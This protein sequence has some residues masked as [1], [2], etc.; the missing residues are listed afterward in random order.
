ML[1]S[2]RHPLLFALLLAAGGVAV[3]R[4]GTGDDP[5][6]T[7]AGSGTDAGSPADAA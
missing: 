4:C 3:A 2:S 7:D 1:T 6:A 5:P